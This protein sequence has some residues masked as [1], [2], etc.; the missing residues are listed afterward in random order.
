[1]EGS[2]AVCNKEC[3][4]YIRGWKIGDFLAEILPNFRINLCYIE[5]AVQG[6]SSSRVGCYLSFA[7]ACASLAVWRC[8]DAEQR[9]ITLRRACR[10][11]SRWMRLCQTDRRSMRP[12]RNLQ[13]PRL[14]TFP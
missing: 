13:D 2:L 4:G 12:S 11:P 8:V 6:E 3:V 14:P 10:W 7:E 9:F 1:M 5:G